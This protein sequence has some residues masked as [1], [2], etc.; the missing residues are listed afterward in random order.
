MPLKEI[1]I[2]YDRCMGCKSCEIACAVA[3]SESRS[4]LGAIM[5]SEKPLK[6]IF[7]ASGKNGKVPI[8]CRH[9]EDAPCIDACVADV[10]HKNDK[11]AVTNEDTDYECTGCFMCVMVCPYGVIRA[12]GKRA[13][14]CDMDCFSD[15]G[16]PACV[17]ACP[18]KAIRYQ[19]VDD[20]SDKKRYDFL[21]KEAL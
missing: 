11:G 17:V 21:A 16:E 7:V 6:R 1:F 2:R 4:F 13:I 19:T 15:D 3:H 5:N 9:C 8:T 10:M 14:K 12:D 18:T 20:Y